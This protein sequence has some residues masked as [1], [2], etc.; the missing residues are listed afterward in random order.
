MTK[1]FKEQYSFAERRNEYNKIRKSYPE[2]VPVI[3]EHGNDK[4]LEIGKKKFLI[5]IG[6]TY[7]QTIHVIKKHC[8]IDSTQ[9]IMMMVEDV[10]PQASRS[11]E[12][13]YIKYKADDGFLYV[14][15]M[16]ESVFG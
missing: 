11:I 14:T 3:V 6:L 13:I 2:R 16:R 7:G 1:S 15:L 8:K 9:S 10:V 5:P 12:D 4:T